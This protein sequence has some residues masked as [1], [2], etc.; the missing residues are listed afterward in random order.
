VLDYDLVLLGPALALLVAHGLEQGFRR[1]EISA[2][3]FCWIVPIGAR[4]LAFFAHV[5][6]G[7]L[8]VTVLFILAAGRAMRETGSLPRLSRSAASS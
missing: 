1:W 7:L 5:P 3:A 2:M 4:A 8:A 6:G